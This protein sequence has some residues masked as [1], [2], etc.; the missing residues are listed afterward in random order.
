MR[1]LFSLAV[2]TA[3]A[4]VGRSI[5]A[6]LPLT[7]SPGDEDDVMI[8]A[9]NTVNGTTTLQEPASILNPLDIALVNNFGG[10]MNAYVSGKDVNG[11]VVLLGTDGEWYYPDAGGSEVPVEIT[12]DL[13]I[14]LNG[15]GETTTITLPDY[16]SSGRVWVAQGTLQFYTVMDANG[17]SQLVEPSA[18]NPSDPSA[19]VNW[20]FIELTNNDSGIYANISYVDFVGLPLGMSLTLSSGE[21]QTVVGLAKGAVDDICA[22]MVAQAAEDGQPWD[23]MCM[24]GSSGNALRILA[25]NMYL[26]LNG[27]AMSGYYDEY[28]ASVWSRYSSE[29]LVVDTQGAAGEVS[30]RASGDELACDGDN[31]S[32]SKPSVGDIWGCNSGPFAIE[33]GDNDVHRAVVPRLCAAFTRSTLLLDGGNVTP[34]LSSDSYYTVSPTSH[35]SR[36]V[37]EYE[38][39]SRGYAFSYDDVNPSG[40]NAAGVVSGGSPTLLTVSIGGSS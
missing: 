34:G 20:G 35:Y 17:I 30:C 12:A 25:P 37:H 5:A 36:I 9:E 13:A 24:K 15:E 7:V 18:V 8:T 31:R 21:T 29:D 4:F 3:A 26:S 28:V 33:A 40:Q 10:G 19:D 11:A 14:A 1:G 38:P 23:E 27:D 22:E 2:A 39:D 16:L 32:Y 6:P